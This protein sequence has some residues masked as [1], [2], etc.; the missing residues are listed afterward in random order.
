MKTTAKNISILFLIAA[1]IAAS[2]P[3]SSANGNAPDT[4]GTSR[5]AAKHES[6]RAAEL[7][8]EALRGAYLSKSLD[9]FF[10]RAVEEP[11]FSSSDM[12]VRVGSSFSR[13]DTLDLNIVTDHALTEGDKTVL[14]THWQKRLARRDN[15]H[16]E[17]Q[18][19]HADFIFRLEDGQAKLLDIQKENPF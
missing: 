19:G 2:A 1:G 14:K 17:I 10:E 16:V 11:Y 12:K 9:H 15:G 13:Y 6:E 18:Q 8:L 5:S 4:A 3:P 7:T